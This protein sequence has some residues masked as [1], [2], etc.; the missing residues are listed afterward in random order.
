[1]LISYYVK[2]EK[3]IYL[4]FDKIN[5]ECNCNQKTE[6]IVLILLYT[7]NIYIYLLDMY[8]LHCFLTLSENC[9]VV[10][11]AMITCKYL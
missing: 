3:L 8:S 9:R 5:Y 4:Y 2:Y 1:M 11:H 6:K 7:Y 10:Y